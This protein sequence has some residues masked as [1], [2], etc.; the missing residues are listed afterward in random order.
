[1][2]LSEMFAEQFGRSFAVVEGLL[3]SE[4]GVGE[5]RGVCIGGVSSCGGSGN[6][7]AIRFEIAPYPLSL[8]FGTLLQ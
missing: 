4:G 7:L 8:P 6:Q 1:M 5:K 2:P 3:E